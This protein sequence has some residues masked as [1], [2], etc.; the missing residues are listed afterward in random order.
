[1][2][3]FLEKLLDPH[4]A[5][6]F[7]RRQFPQPGGSRGL[8]HG[9]QQAA[10]IGS[11]HLRQRLAFALGLRKAILIKAT[12]VA[13]KPLRRDLSQEPVG[14]YLCQDIECMAKGLSN[15]FQPMETR[16]WPPRHASSRCADVLVL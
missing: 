15:T 16:E 6:R 5:Q 3:L 14:S 1:M 10:A 4:A 2:S 8:I 9:R 12:A 11:N 7:H 13:L